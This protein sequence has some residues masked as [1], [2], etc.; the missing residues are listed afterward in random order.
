MHRIAPS[1][2]T[3]EDQRQPAYGA[4]VHADAHHL[5]KREVGLGYA[6]DIAHRTAAEIDG[7]ET[8]CLGK[9]GGQ[10]IEDDGRFNQRVTAD[11]LAEIAH[12][13]L[14]RNPRVRS[15]GRIGQQQRCG[16]CGP[17]KIFGEA[18]K[19]R[20][21][22]R[23]SPA[24]ENLQVRCSPPAHPPRYEPSCPLELLCASQRKSAGHRASIAAAASNATKSHAPVRRLPR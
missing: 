12:D 8:G 5:G 23:F 11:H 17:I 21:H 1:A 3:V 24:G 9:L 13:L 18:A 14:L 22:L 15:L 6:L 16:S 10:R 4:D 20:W 19:P 2:C 7:G